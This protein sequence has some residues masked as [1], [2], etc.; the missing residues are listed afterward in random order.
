MLEKPHPIPWFGHES[1]PDHWK[2]GTV[3]PWILCQAMM[4]VCCWTP[5]LPSDQWSLHGTQQPLAEIQRSEA[6]PRIESHESPV[7]LHE[8]LALSFGGTQLTPW[9]T[10]IKNY[11]KSQVL[12]GKIS[13]FDWAMFNSKLLVYPLLTNYWPR[14]DHY[15]W[16][17]SIIS[18]VCLFTR[19]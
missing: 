4:T 13:Y 2:K 7:N 6:E 8:Y 18:H 11:G 9:S 19:G 5:G 1:F 15:K 10:L 16:L 17:F 14:F 3:N 12:N